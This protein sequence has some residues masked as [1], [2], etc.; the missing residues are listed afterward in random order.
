MFLANST[1]KPSYTEKRKRRHEQMYREFFT[2][3][4]EEVF[5]AIGEWPDS[6]ENGVRFLTLRDAFGQSLVFSY[7][8]LERSV[9]VRWMNDQGV[10]L[11]DVYREG[12]TRL[13]FPLGKSTKNISIE[14]HTDECAGVM[15]IQISPQLEIQDRLLFQ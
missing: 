4:D 9:R 11:M 2:P 14:F 7:A 1:S 12:A 15:G 6:D 5:E 8:A 3:T 13:S 10:Q